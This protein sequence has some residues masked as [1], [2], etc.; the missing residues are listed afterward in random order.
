[1][2]DKLI[3]FKQNSIRYISG[4]GPS[5][6]GTNDDYG[7]TTLITTDAGCVNSRSIVV[8]PDGLMFK[9]S[10]GIYFINR[11][12]QVSYIGAPVERWNEF[13]VT[14][15]ILMAKNNQVRFTLDNDVII[16]Y[17]YYVETWAV[18]TPLAAVDSV[19]WNDTHTLIASN[20]R[21]QPQ[22]VDVWTDNGAG[23][24]MEIMTGWIPFGGIQGYQRLYQM[25][26]LGNY[27]SSHDLQ[28]N[29]FYDYNNAVGQTINVIPLTPGVYG[30]DDYG[31]ETP[32]GGEFNLYQY[33]L[34]N[35]RQKCMSV[36]LQLR[37]VAKSGETL[38]RGYELSNI[39][40]QYG[41]IGGANRIRNVQTFG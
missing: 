24:S 36:K 15:A 37:D 10:K 18:F 25:T 31:T 2:D 6:D 17:D 26:L 5:P 21:V 33:Q 30:T 19:V 16:V 13:Y 9:S 32:Y 39:R 34:N 22:S 20:G 7:S 11:G 1:M 12:L 4:Q 28:C 27:D 3:I 29:L 8:T 40:F 23:Y 14:S 41:V 35:S 38:R